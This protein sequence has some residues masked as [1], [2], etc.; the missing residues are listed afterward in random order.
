MNVKK[1]VWTQMQV[2]EDQLQDA[3]DPLGRFGTVDETKF[4]S[5]RKIEKNDIVWNN[6]PNYYNIGTVNYMSA[7]EMVVTVRKA[8]NLGDILSYIGGLML[9]VYLGSDIF[10]GLYARTNLTALV[11]NR[12]YS[13]KNNEG[14]VKEMD[15]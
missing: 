10:I 2:R 14:G 3:T 15:M 7:T 6:Y 1:P 11:A 5:F 8:I 9:V 12:L 4:M 13:W